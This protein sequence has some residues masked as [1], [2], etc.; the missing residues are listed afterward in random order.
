[1]QQTTKTLSI[2]PFPEQTQ[3]F[4]DTVVNDVG[5]TDALDTFQCLRQKDFASLNASFSTLPTP[6]GV[7]WGP[8]FDGDLISE[9]SSKLLREGKFPHVPTIIGANTDEGTFFALAVAPQGSNTDADVAA[10]FSKILSTYLHHMSNIK[11]L[12]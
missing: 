4:Y 7:T 2:D 3:P 5:C 12:C 6:L 8:T 9:F 11:D 1:M 10:A